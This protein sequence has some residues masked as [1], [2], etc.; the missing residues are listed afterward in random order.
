VSRAE[1]V[2]DWVQRVRARFQTIDL[3]V[4]NAGVNVKQRAI[5]ELTP[6]SWQQQV[7]TNL[8]GA[9]YCI[10]AV[11]LHMLE[12]REG[13]VINVCSIAGLRPSLLGGAAYSA[14]KFGM[15]SLGMCLAEEVRE[16]GIRV[17]NIYPGEVDTPILEN[18]PRPVTEE[19][20]QK[21]L[22]SEDVAAAVIFIATLPPRA[23]VPELVIK[24]TSQAF[25]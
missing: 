1:Q 10:H 5:R 14:A 2:A 18:R 7:Q 15:H 4:N 13:M 11:L 23:S 3:L 21:I 19:Q 22:R 20:R 6:E 24:P 9:F 8:D 17:S 25:L 16:V 12:R